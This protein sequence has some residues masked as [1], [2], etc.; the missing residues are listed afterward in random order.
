LAKVSPEPFF[1]DILLRRHAALPPKISRYLC[2][3]K[4][5]DG[6]EL[7]LFISNQQALKVKKS[8]KSKLVQILVTTA[9]AF[10]LQHVDPVY[11]VYW[12]K[13]GG[14]LVSL[15]VEIYIC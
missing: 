2:F 9:A 8:K 11:K 7:N 13:G 5:Y 3:T 10:V 12:G 6:A 4:K 14:Q 15:L 1:G